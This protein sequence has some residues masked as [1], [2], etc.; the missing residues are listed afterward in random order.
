M[1]GRTVVDFA[2]N[3]VSMNESGHLALRVSF[4]DGLELVMRAT[5]DD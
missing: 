5:R 1:L 3:P 2:L 4:S